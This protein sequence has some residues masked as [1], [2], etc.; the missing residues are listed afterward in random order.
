MLTTSQFLFTLATM[1]LA[2]DCEALFWNDGSLELENKEND[3]TFFSRDQVRKIR[4]TLNRS[5]IS[6]ILDQD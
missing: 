2:T 6:A 3:S 1:F 4:D 5:D